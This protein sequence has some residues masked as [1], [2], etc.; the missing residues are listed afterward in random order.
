M[1]QLE[2]EARHEMDGT[3]IA[4]W[5]NADGPDVDNNPDPGMDAC[6]TPR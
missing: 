4:A 2:P 1:F 5:V 3:Q 6:S